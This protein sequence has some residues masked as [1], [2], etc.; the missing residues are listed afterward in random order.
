M[1]VAPTTGAVP[2]S[3]APASITHPPTERSV[4]FVAFQESSPPTPASDDALSDELED[5]EPVEWQAASQAASLSE[6][7]SESMCTSGEFIDSGDFLNSGEF[8]VSST[9]PR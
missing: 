4:A 8:R 3:A 7:Q 5:D 2:P 9:A 6:S 1:A